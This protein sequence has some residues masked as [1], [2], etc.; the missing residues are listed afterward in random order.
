VRCT[1]APSTTCS[2]PRPRRSHHRGCSSRPGFDA[3]RD[4]PLAD[5]ALAAGDYAELATKVAALAP[6]PGRLVLFL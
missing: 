5:H 2:R 3:H 4:D 1:G 6:G